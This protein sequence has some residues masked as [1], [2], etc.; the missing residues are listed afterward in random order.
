MK[1]IIKAL[2]IM[3][4]SVSMLACSTAKDKVTTVST[5]EEAKEMMEEFFSGLLEEER[6]SI[7]SLDEEGNETSHTVIDGEKMHIMD[8]YSDYYL[9]EENGIRYSIITGEDQP[10]EDFFSYEVYKGSLDMIVNMFVLGYFD[11]DDEAGITYSA[12]KTEKTDGT[13]EIL[14][15]IEV[16]DEDT[17]ALITISGDKNADAKVTAL[18]WKAEYGE[19]VYNYAYSFSYDESVE[20]PEYTIIDYSANYIHVDS[21]YATFAEMMDQHKDEFFSYH[22]RDERVYVTIEEDGRHYQLC[23]EFTEEQYE[24]YNALDYMA[25]DYFDQM[26]ACYKE[27]AIVDCVD[28]T[29]A[30]LTEEERNA[31][32]GKTVGELV[33]E[34]FENS[35]W[36]MYDDE[37]YL[38]M[39]KMLMDYSVKITLPEGF[40]IESDFEFEDL[41]DAVVEEVEFE[42]ASFSA[43]PME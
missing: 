27:L 40:D 15:T 26:V 8:E 17:S 4:L 43:I 30:I 19:E 21:P 38:F 5:K 13:Q 9:F 12:T 16:P 35:G 25:D 29:A 7:I 42:D 6:I 28:F 31:L 32:I 23:G 41:Y 20:I 14:T 39:E 10:Y 37:A 36:S 18:N 33:D 34:G 11:A 2:L 3:F 22:N 24:A 1:K